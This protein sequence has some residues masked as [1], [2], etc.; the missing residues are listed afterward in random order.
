[1]GKVQKFGLLSASL[2]VI[3]GTVGA[4]IFLL[5]GQCFAIMRT[6][7]LLIYVFAALLSMALAACFAEV[8]GMFTRYGGPYV[9]AREAFGEF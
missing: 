7:S 9:Y 2:L 4:G 6:S 8:G 1:M 3:N 5:P